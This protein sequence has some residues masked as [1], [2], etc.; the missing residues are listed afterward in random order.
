MAVAAVAA[1]A[2]AVALAVAA[3]AHQGQARTAVTDG[4]QRSAASDWRLDATALGLTAAGSTAVLLV[5]RRGG[6][7]GTRRPVPREAAR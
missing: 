3:P 7:G 4:G 2:V 1:A 5:L 6:R